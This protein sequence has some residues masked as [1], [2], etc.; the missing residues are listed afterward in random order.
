MV[1]DKLKCDVLIIHSDINQ[2]QREASVNAFKEGKVNVLIAT[3]VLAR[4]MDIPMV[5]LIIQTEPP[6]EIDSYIHRAGRTARAGRTGTC[7]SLYTKMTEGLLT[8]IEHAAKIKFKRIGAPQ[9]QDIINASIRDIKENLGT[10]HQTSVSCFK[11]EATDLLN[12]YQ[13]DE[14][15][16]RLLAFISGNTKEMKS[17]SMLIGAEGFVTYKLET[18]QP[19]Q[20]AS[21]A[22]SCLRKIIPQTINDKIRG[23]R[24]FKNMQGSVFDV[25]ED[26]VK[27]IEVAIMNF[28]QLNAGFKLSKCDE[29]P[30]LTTTD[31]RGQTGGYGGQSRG[32][33]GG[34]SRGGF[35]GQSRGGY[36]GGNSYGGYRGR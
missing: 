7:I 9:R 24:T 6:K 10:I 17:K 20:S 27:A 26:C 15:V 35:G 31:Q 28:K 34:Q 36:G 22:W 32:G 8:R 16:S 18:D 33:F 5:D 25:E 11:K 21:F 23:M 1:S 2:K 3:D 14:L 12:E 29:L 19:F 4:G 30:E 13:P